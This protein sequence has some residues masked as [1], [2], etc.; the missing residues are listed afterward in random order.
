MLKFFDESHTY[1]YNG[2]VVPSVS[3][4]LRFMSREVYGDINKYILDR[5]AER[6]TAV[7]AATQVLDE[8]GLVDCPE[9]ICGYLEAYVAFRREHSAEWKY[10]EKPLAHPDLLYAGTIDRAG[11]VDGLST[12]VDIKTN[13]AVKKPL[14]KAQLNGY[15]LLM[16]TIGFKANRLCCLQLMAN[17][18]YRLYRVSIDDT[19]FL[20]CYR[21]HFAMQKK[22]KRGTIE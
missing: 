3:E 22:H 7:H 18:K 14:V 20:S 5:A 11:V 15:K 17:G 21:L 13:S 19:E 6:G 10:I 12:I 9:E 16:D 4:I 2:L 8:H 1:E